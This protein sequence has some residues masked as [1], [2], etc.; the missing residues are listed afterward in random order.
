MMMKRVR[1]MGLVPCALALVVILSG[2]PSLVFF[3]DKALEDAVRYSI[4]KPLG[5]LNTTDLLE[6]ESLDASDLNIGDL[7]GLELCTRMT[8]LNLSNNAVESLLP[9]RDLTSLTSLNLSGNRLGNIQELSGLILLTSLSLWGADQEIVDYG[10]LVANAV[11]AGGLRQATVSVA[12]ESTLSSD[13]LT[14]QPWFAEDHAALVR[15]GVTVVFI[16][17]LGD[18]VSAE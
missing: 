17:E 9:L 11:G 4:N 15:S 2:C 13:G 7:R 1:W 3:P 14:V 10:P 5:F 18:E 12:S 6:V 16:T 8:S